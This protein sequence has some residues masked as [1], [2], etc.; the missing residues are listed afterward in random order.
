MRIETKQC[1][2]LFIDLQERL[3][4]V[5][6]EKE[7]LLSNCIKLAEGFKVLEVPTLFTQQY[8][9]GLGQTLADLTACY[10]N[11]SYLE[12]SSFSCM[13]EPQFVA[14]LAETGKCIV[15]L[16]GIESHV[17]LLQTAVD[18]KAAGYIPVIL[19]DCISSRSL[20]EKGVALLRFQ[21]EGMTL[22]T[23]ESILF[24]LTRYSTAPGFKAIS[25]LIK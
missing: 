16:A 23:S 19:T 2:A 11:F 1:V 6:A 5:M 7:Q 22:S 24:E 18:L 9:K 20:T 13:D 10:S 12:K 14:A 3:F 17:C 25:K 8:T 15:L 21:Q 4:P